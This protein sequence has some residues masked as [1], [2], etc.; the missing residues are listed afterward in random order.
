[1]TRRY[2]GTP[3][4]FICADRCCFRLHTQVNGANGYRVST[5]GCYH[6]DWTE[7]RKAK[8]EPVA[9]GGHGKLYET[10][11]FRLRKGEPT[12]YGSVVESAATDTVRAAELAHERLCAKYEAM[13]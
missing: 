2:I 11:V 12:S 10:F 13:R 4:H 9:V 5:V 7:T 3:G 8:G 1:M 6:P